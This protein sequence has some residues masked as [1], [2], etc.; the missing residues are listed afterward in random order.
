MPK[1]TGACE[2]YFP[3]W[4]YDVDRKQCGQFIYGGCLGNANN[5]KTRDE[6][7][8]LCSESDDIGKR[9]TYV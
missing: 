2:G 7:E 3:T 6:C 1:I 9:I 4:Y 5:F 8:A